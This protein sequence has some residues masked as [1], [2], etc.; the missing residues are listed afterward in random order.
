MEAGGLLD[1][2]GPG[3]SRADHLHVALEAEK[4]AEVITSLGDVVDDEDSDLVGH[5]APEGFLFGWG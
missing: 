2:L 3:R 1:G 4:L 5:A